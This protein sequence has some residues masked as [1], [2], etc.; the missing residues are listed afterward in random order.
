MG[1]A[2]GE[3]MGHLQLE[4]FKPE[5]RGGSAAYVPTRMACRPQRW[6]RRTCVASGAE[7]FNPVRTHEMVS[8]AFCSLS[9]MCG[10]VW[11]ASPGDPGLRDTA[12]HNA[13]V[14]FQGR[15]YVMST[16]RLRPEGFRAPRPREFVVQRKTQHGS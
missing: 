11:T 2:R 7:S 4:M 5:L 13:H 3:L 1:G 9:C 15:R 16:H 14:P 8:S 12:G 10:L 6:T